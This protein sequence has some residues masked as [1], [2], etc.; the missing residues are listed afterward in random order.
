MEDKDLIRG[1]RKILAQENRNKAFH[2]YNLFNNFIRLSYESFDM[3]KFVNRFRLSK[4][5]KER[6]KDDS[7]DNLIKMLETKYPLFI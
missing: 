2:Y 7:L 6:C 3:N 5:E 4:N 1:Y